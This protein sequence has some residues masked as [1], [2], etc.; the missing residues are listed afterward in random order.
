M[1]QK[2]SQVKRLDDLPENENSFWDG[3]DVH[4]N[5]VPKKIVEDDKHYFVRMTGRQAQCNHCDWGFELDP[6]DK[7]IDGHLYDK[8]GILI[9]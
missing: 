3:A 2:L 5:L 8:S 9:I 6:G 1:E 7:I 4:G